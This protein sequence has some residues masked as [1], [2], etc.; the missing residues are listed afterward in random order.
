MLKEIVLTGGPSGGKTS[1]LDYASRR[2]RSRGMRIF[3]VPEVATMIIT[4]GIPDIALF[5]DEGGPRYFKIEKQMILTQMG[6]RIRFNDLAAA[7]KDDSCIILYDRAEMDARAYITDG[8]ETILRSQGTSIPEIRD[9]YHGVIHFVTAAEG[10]EEHYGNANNKA[11]Y[12]DLEGARYADKRTLQGWVGHPHLKIVDNSTNF[13][14]KMERGMEVLD[15]MIGFPRPIEI[16]RKFLLRKVPDFGIP[17]LQHAQKTFIEQTYLKDGTRIRKQSQDSYCTHYKTFKNEIKPGVREEIEAFITAREYYA[18]DEL[19]YN[20]RSTIHKNRYYFVYKNQ[21]FE[22]DVFHEPIHNVCVLE[23]ELLKENDEV[24]LPP[25][26]DVEKE[27]TSDPDY[28]NSNI[29]KQEMM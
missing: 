14:Q 9:S 19:F 16:E 27:V 24:E 11:R 4:G 12:E 15:R 29:A 23:I 17:E 7:I 22:L 28:S 1:F 10:A 13:D 6:L 25:F 5:A 18:H 2:L 21:Y 20:L 8:M 26:L 3:T